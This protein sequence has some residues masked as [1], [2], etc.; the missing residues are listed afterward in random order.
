MPQADRL[1]TQRGD[2]AVKVGSQRRLGADVGVRGG[3]AGSVADRSDGE[4]RA[5]LLRRRDADQ[6]SRRVRHRSGRAMDD[7][8][9]EID[10]QNTAWLA[11]VLDERGWPGRAVVG[12]DGATAAWL[13]A[14]H[15]DAQPRLQRR[16]LRQV[17]NAVRAGEAPLWHWAYLLDRV[18]VNE[19]RAQRFGTQVTVRAGDYQPKR[20]HDPDRVDA[21]CNQVGLQPLTTYLTGMRDEHPPEQPTVCCPQCGAETPFELPEAGQHTQ[22]TCR[23]GRIT[24]VSVG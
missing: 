21:C 18:L 19:H 13:L 2:C 22:L 3:H 16:C 24:T 10:R 8:D 1:L 7:R 23:C 5:E 11:R 6:A 12:E 17:A 9:P 20:L 14:Q 4:L 15:A